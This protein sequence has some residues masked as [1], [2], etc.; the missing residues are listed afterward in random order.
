MTA[1]ARAGGGVAFAIAC[2]PWNPCT[3]QVLVLTH[4]KAPVEER[5]PYHC[6]RCKG[7]RPLVFKGTLQ[8]RSRTSAFG[9]ASSASC[10]TEKERVSGHSIP[11]GCLVS[12]HRGPS[13]L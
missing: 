3:S 9:D 13:V 4:E 10:G 11:L 7:V 2:T 12:S 5:M 6:L 1:P 8:R